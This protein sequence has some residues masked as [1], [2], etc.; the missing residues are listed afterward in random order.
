M[1]RYKT[2]DPNGTPMYPNR[3]CDFPF[4]HLKIGTE[5]FSTN[6]P[7]PGPHGLDTILEV[8]EVHNNT[9]KGWVHM[10]QLSIP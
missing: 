9:S 8:T 7:V 6:A 5:V 4:K 3:N 2:N 10:S 1:A